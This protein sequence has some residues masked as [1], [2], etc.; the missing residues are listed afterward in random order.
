[1]VLSSSLGHYTLRISSQEVI[2]IQA[3]I[4]NSA[5]KAEIL[6]NRL[7]SLGWSHYRLAKEVAKVRKEIYGEEIANPRT[8]LTGINN[9]L[10][11][12]D[13]SNGKILECIIKAMGGTLSVKWVNEK[14][15]TIT[16]EVDEDL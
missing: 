12:P 3:W 5:L 8:L 13:R 11:N 2:M 7:N 16:E 15:V 4:D 10:K 9:C 14:I 6:T 1:M